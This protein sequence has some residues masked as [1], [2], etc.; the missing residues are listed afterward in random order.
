MPKTSRY[1][2][3]KKIKN[4]AHRPTRLMIAGKLALIKQKKI[5]NAMFGNSGRKHTPMF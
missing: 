1:R 2:M 5:I 3:A 4:T